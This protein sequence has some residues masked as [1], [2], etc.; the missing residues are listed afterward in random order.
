VASGARYILGL[1]KVEDWRC[2]NGAVVKIVR[3]L[4][5]VSNK[6]CAAY[7]RWR[8]LPVIGNVRMLLGPANIKESIGGLTKAIHS[9]VLIT[10]LSNQTIEFIFGLERDYPSTVN[11]IVRTCDKLVSNCVLCERFFCCLCLL[12]MGLMISYNRPVQTGVRKQR[13]LVRSMPKDSSDLGREAAEIAELESKGTG[14][15]APRL[16]YACHTTLT[17]R[18][19]RG[20]HLTTGRGDGPRRVTLPVWVGRNI[21]GVTQARMREQIQEFLLNS[22]DGACA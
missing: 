20:A 1:E 10:L 19:S 4:R 2:D 21:D 8:S 13:I 9:T 17:S 6:E 12:P 14:Q 22:E 16:C 7:V 18:S 15:L 5:E 11:A 3:P